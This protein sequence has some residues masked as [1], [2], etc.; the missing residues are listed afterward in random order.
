LRNCIARFALDPSAIELEVT[1]SLVMRMPELA[2]ARLQALRDMG[3]RLAIDDFGTGYSSLTY[4]QTLPVHALKL[5]RSFIPGINDS[6]R[7]LSICRNAIQM[8]RDL[9]LEVVAEG[10]ET[11]H[12]AQALRELG[13]NLLQGYHYAMPLSPE[14]LLTYLAA[15]PISAKGADTALPLSG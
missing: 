11:A 10:V 7:A 1:E 2:I 15:W 14:A 3:L 4:L 5:D 8:G 12:Q 9:G 6:Q 13:C